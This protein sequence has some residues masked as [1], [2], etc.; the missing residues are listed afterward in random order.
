M[1]LGFKVPGFKE[2]WFGILWLSLGELILLSLVCLEG[3]YRVRQEA[4]EGGEE[5]GLRVS[6]WGHNGSPLLSCNRFILRFT[7]PVG[8][9]FLDLYMSDSKAA[10][11]NYSNFFF[12]S[13]C[14]PI[15]YELPMMFPSP[16]GLSSWQ[17]SW[18][19]LGSHFVTAWNKK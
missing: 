3:V 14:L 2:K 10:S 8:D 15:Y 13:F 7:R 17:S 9:W 12:L 1:F 16:L 19:M 5:V 6:S 18:P 11:L 4:T